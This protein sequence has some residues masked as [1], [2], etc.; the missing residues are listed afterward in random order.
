MDRRPKTASRR[1]FV[2]AKI[3]AEASQERM[4]Q[5]QHATRRK[6]NASGPDEGPRARR[7]RCREKGRPLDK[8]LRF[9]EQVHHSQRFSSR[10]AKKQKGR[11]LLRNP[12][13]GQPLRNCVPPAN[14]EKTGNEAKANG[15]DPGNARQ[16]SAASLAGIR[17]PS[18]R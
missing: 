14:R 3:H 13:Q 5:S 16:K 8:R 15:G 4:V 11:R 10:T 9:P 7:N 1:L 2:A 17:A 6:I 12:E 18:Q